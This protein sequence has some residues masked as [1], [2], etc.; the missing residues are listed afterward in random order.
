MFSRWLKWNWSPGP[1]SNSIFKTSTVCWF[2]AVFLFSVAAV[3]DYRKHGGFNTN[4]FSYISRHQK[5]YTGLMGVKSK[6]PQDLV[7]LGGSWGESISLTLAYM[8]SLTCGP[9]PHL[10]TQQKLVQSFAHGIWPPHLPSSSPFKD[11]VITMRLPGRSRTIC[12]L[13]DLHP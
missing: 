7:P 4:L 6:H 12:S 8:H 1:F 3:A 13:Q 11:L 10:Q 2:L 5:P 9:C